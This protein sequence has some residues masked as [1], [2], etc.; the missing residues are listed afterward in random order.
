[1]ML[2]YALSIT[3]DTIVGGSAEQALIVS[4]NWLSI[5]SIDNGQCDRR[6]ILRARIDRVDW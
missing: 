6:G 5:M 1:M 2:L 4:V 3:I